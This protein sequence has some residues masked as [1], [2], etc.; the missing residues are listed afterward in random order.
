MEYLSYVWSFGRPQGSDEEPARA[1][2]SDQA[3]E[4]LAHW[5]T[6]PLLDEGGVNER[7]ERST[8]E[9]A[10]EGEVFVL[11]SRSTLKRLGVW[12]AVAPMALGASLPSQPHQHTLTTF[13]ATWPRSVHLES[14]ETVLSRNA[15]RT[16]SHNWLSSC[17]LIQADTLHKKTSTKDPWAHAPIVLAM[18]GGLLSGELSALQGEYRDTERI[19]THI[20]MDA[21]KRVNAVIE[22]LVRQDPEPEVMGVDESPYELLDAK[23]FAERMGVADQTVYNQEK[24]GRLIAVLSPGRERGRRFPSFQLSPRLNRELHQTAIAMYAS[25]G[26]DMT[27]Y[28]DF[29]R[30]RHEAFGGSTG[31]DFLLNRVANPAL[32][33]LEP[34][35]L[36]GLFLEVAEEDLH[37]AVS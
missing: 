5:L 23:A 4:Q 29:L 2:P 14:F 20:F 18:E 15:A 30:T 31:V 37:R 35:D 10:P 6:N 26:R 34:D 13:K 25:R 7:R 1:L 36:A 9:S 24:A 11:V 8:G 32:Q 3:P 28:W 17:K 22:G 19:S 16:Y 21:F 12:E 33:D 27:L